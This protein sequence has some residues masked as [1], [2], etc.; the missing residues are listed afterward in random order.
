MSQRCHK[1]VRKMDKKE[2]RCT[3]HLMYFHS[4]YYLRV[5]INVIKEKI[6]TLQKNEM[7]RKSTP[8][9]MLRPPS[10]H[11][12]RG[13]CL[14]QPRNSISMSG[15]KLKNIYRFPKFAIIKDTNHLRV[16]NSKSLKEV[17]GKLKLNKKTLF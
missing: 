17:L 2:T 14:N 1:Y 10:T 8:E 11:K 16:V 6:K 15:F 12:K 5:N 7:E 13:N 9:I 4:Y 3:Y